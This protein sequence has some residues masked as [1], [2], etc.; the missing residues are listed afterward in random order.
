MNYSPIRITDLH[1]SHGT[2][3]VLHGVSAEFP[4]ESISA[5]LGA[6]GSGKTTLLEHVLGLRKPPPG[7][8]FLFGEDVANASRDELNA[9]RQRTGMLFQDG[10]L[11]N[12][13]TILENCS[14]PLEQHTKLPD[15]LI[16]RI[17]MTKLRLVGLEDA[18]SRYPHQLSGGMRKRAAIARAIALDPELLLCDE[19][20]SGLD[21]LTAK[22]LDELL[23]ELQ[24]TLSMT[25][26][27]ISHD[28]TSIRRVA[29][30]IF[31]LHSGRII[32][33]GTVEEAERSPLAELARYFEAGA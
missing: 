22:G 31:F 20:S 26:V 23:V 10:A 16:R 5:L 21:P 29:D 33:R 4:A 28:L 1:V 2:T 32:F 12:S 8:V 3:E 11:I 18:G 30:Q 7:S 25:I 9:L 6:S 15:D 24:S 27:I 17:V 13:R 14:V 19:P